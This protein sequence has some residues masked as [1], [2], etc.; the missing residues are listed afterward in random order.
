[1]KQVLESRAGCL[2]GHP[3]LTAPCLGAGL[4]KAKDSGLMA[5]AFL[6]MGINSCSGDPGKNGCTG[7]VNCQQKLWGHCSSQDNLQGMKHGANFSP[8]E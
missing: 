4:A 7:K 1:M 2:G 3:G 5:M 8:S 6:A